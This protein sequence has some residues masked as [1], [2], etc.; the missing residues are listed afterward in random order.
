MSVKHSKSLI[1]EHL[2]R[3]VKFI[4]LHLKEAFHTLALIRSVYQIGFLA[5]NWQSY[6][7]ADQVR[8][9][10]QFNQICMGVSVT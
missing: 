8:V 10:P 9:G 7:L 6:V 2:G 1:S 3:V 4:V 5:E